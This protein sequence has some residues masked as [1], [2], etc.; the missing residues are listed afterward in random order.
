MKIEFNT[1]AMA[2][3]LGLVGQAVPARTPKAI[4]RMFHLKTADKKLVI[5]G[6]DLEE[7]I[8]AIIDKVKIIKSGEALI[9]ADKFSLIVRESSDDVMQIET[10][11]IH[12]KIT[13]KDS[14]FNIF[15]A[16]VADYPLLE[17][18]KPQI[19][20]T[21][22]LEKLQQG[23][24]KT[25]FATAKESTRYELT[26][27]LFELN[28]KKVII[29]ATDGRRLAQSS[30][31]AGDIAVKTE[32]KIIVPAR[33]LR[34]LLKLKSDDKQKITAS[35]C[36]N[37][38]RFDCGD[39]TVISNL[40]KG[41]FPKYEDSIPKYE[42]RIEFPTA[43]FTS[44]VRRAAL[45]A[46]KESA[47][48]KLAITKNSAVFSSHATETGDS[49]IDMQIE[50]AGEPIEIGFN[51][52]YLLDALKSLNSAFFTMEFESWD[53]PVIF[54]TKYGQLYLQMPIMLG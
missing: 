35:L 30:L 40:L 39:V 3:V 50:Y 52:F 14:Q 53:R 41:T 1:E 37:I 19:V 47:A 51:P 22:E 8:I 23:I 2:E 32:R 9:N 13:G 15:G 12:S 16:P 11:D 48:I 49:E 27:C 31:A 34:M 38:I 26:G 36:D 10:E 18:K 5:S 21:A 17:T 44:A 33:A 20:F 43:N 45:L 6:T 42:K 25:I 54:K 29:T 46:T 4:L 28:K 24:E 7:V